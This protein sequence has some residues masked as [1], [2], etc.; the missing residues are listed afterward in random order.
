[1]PAQRTL[2]RGPSG[3]LEGEGEGKMS[4]RVAGGGTSARCG[5][6]AIHASLTVGPLIDRQMGSLL[7][8]L[9]KHLPSLPSAQ[10]N[11]PSPLACTK[12]YPLSPPAI[13]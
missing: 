2:G 1:M 8:S 4:K 3:E 6:K 10:K 5:A 11:L 13:L 12:P 7:L 9:Q